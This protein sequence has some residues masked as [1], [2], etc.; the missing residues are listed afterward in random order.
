MPSGSLGPQP[1]DLEAVEDAAQDGDEL[2]VID[3]ENDPL[4]V[5]VWDQS[6]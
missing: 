2:P 3:R 6:N 4:I 1:R 5:D